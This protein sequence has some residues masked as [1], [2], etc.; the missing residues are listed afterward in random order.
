MKRRIDVLYGVVSR[1]DNF[2][3]GLSKV[4]AV[5]S[6]VL[7]IA[8]ML[9]IFAGVFN[10]STFGFT[11]LFVEEYSAL[12][13]IPIAYLTMGYTL[14]WNQHLKIDILTRHVPIRA[15]QVLGIFAAV[16]SFVCIIYMC[17]SAIDWFT[18]TLE[19]KITSSGT[20]RTPLWMV[21]GTIVAGIVI[22]A[23]DMFMLIL[24]RILTMIRQ[25]WYLNFIDDEPELPGNEEVA[26]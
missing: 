23:I 9:I 18:Y 17:Y 4:C 7:M 25:D 22:F 8:V 24:H 5:I 20:L 12:A 1:I 21:S 6:G 15:R 19:R 3:N 26:E 10:R 16:F 11:W 2:F 13:L 14:R